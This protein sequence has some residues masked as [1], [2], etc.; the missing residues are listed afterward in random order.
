M[1]QLYDKLYMSCYYF[2][3]DL[4]LYSIRSSATC[5]WMYAKQPIF[6]QKKANTIE[7][8]PR[9]VLIL[10]KELSYRTYWTNN[11]YPQNV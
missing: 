11:D 5:L 8:I 1:L 10:W 3:N 9:N 2:I 6:Q 7:G 4:V